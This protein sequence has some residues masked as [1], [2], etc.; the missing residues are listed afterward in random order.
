[1]NTIKDIINEQSV[2]NKIHKMLNEI[3]NVVCEGSGRDAAAGASALILAAH[4]FCTSTG[5]SH[6]SFATQFLRME[7]K[8]K[9]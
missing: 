8:D 6:D 4:F 7:E 5:Y 9:S 1:M 2:P 3:V